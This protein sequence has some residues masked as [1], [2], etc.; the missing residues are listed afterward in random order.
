MFFK[1]KFIQNMVLN[2][3]NF[4]KKKRKTLIA[5][6]LGAPKQTPLLPT[7]ADSALRP[8]AALTHDP[9]NPSKIPV[10]ST[11]KKNYGLMKSKRRS[12]WPFHGES[13]RSVGEKIKKKAVKEESLKSMW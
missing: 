9:S 11:G 10:F 12:C 4:D 3:I 7:V 1:S 2:L 8:R 5:G 6:S 13:G